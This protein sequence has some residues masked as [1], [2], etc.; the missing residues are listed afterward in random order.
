MG[1]VTGYVIG[2]FLGH[3]LDP[4]GFV[5]A[6]LGSVFITKWW[7]ILLV[8]LITASIVE[9]LLI[10]TQYTRIWGEGII[11]GSVASC[12]HAAIGYAAVRAFKGRQRNNKT[13]ADPMNTPS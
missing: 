8:G 3:F 11:I 1:Q 12:V 4:I 6:I 2:S 7:Q 5:I 9:T 13:Q 10:M